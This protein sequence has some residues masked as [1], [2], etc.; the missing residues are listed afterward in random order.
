MAKVKESTKAVLLS[1]LVFPGMGHFY[2]KKP[3]AGVMLFGASTVCLFYILTTVV[4]VTKKVMANITVADLPLDIAQI[5]ELVQ[6]SM[7]AVDGSS[8]NTATWVLI[9]LWVIAA[10]DAARL[11]RAVQ[12]A[13]EL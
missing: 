8:A 7:A 5:T 4:S 13:K 6:Q 3:L 10:L 2:L 12:Q 1:T 9:V 11:G